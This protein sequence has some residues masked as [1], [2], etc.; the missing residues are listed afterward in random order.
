[1]WMLLCRYFV[2]SDNDN[3]YPLYH[4]IEINKIIVDLLYGYLKRLVIDNIYT[5]NDTVEESWS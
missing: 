3:Y 2:H 5:G 4:L 1:M